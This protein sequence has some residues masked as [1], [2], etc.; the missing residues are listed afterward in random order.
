[1]QI[2]N[3]ITNITTKEKAAEIK[4]LQ[5]IFNEHGSELKLAKLFLC[6]ACKNTL[7]G[8]A[9]GRKQVSEVKCNFCGHVNHKRIVN[10]ND[11]EYFVRSIYNQKRIKLI[12]EDTIS[13]EVPCAQ[14]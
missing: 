2:K 12:H 13:I 6:T 14:R 8:Y 3:G 9:T 4:E 5:E 10:S 1:M 7:Y 11:V